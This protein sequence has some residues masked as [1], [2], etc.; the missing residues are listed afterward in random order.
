MRGQVVDESIVVPVRHIVEILHANDLCHGL[1][2][3]QLLGRNVAQTDVTDQSLTL[4]FDEF[5]QRF[6]DRSFRRFREPSNS[7][8][9]HVESVQAKISKIVVHAVNEFLP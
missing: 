2:F 7:E 8:I 6:R 5:S 1:R 9:H 3:G 4:E